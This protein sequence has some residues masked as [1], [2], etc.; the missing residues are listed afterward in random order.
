MQVAVDGEQA[1]AAARDPS[2]DLVLLDLML[3][4]MSGLEV[5]RAIRGPRA[6]PRQ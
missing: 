1:L 3:P 6:S 2:L 4:G 5:L